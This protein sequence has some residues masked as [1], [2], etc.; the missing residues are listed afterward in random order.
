MARVLRVHRSQ[1]SLVAAAACWGAA[2]VVSKRALDEIEPLALLPIELVVSV[3]VLGAATRLRHEPLGWSPEL[4]RLA[5]LGVLNPGLAY[6][7][8]LAGLARV[9]ASVSVLL[10]AL[11]PIVILGI[12]FV[13]LR[14]RVPPRLASCMA[15][16]LAGVVMV[17][18]QPGNHA[19]PVG[20]ALTTAGV[21]ACAVYTVLSSRLLVASTTV[22]VV[23]FVQQVAA[24]WFALA[25]FCG[26][27]LVSDPPS[28]AAVSAT[29][30]VSA[31]VA[32]SLYY[33]VAF[34]LYLAG[35][36]GVTASFAGLFIN[37]V[38]V[39][40]IATGYVVLDERL[41]PRQWTG[42]LTVVVAV[43]IAALLLGGRGSSAE[44][45]AERVEA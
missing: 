4:R 34:W 6:A 42:A 5:A 26:S 10:W 19:S 32:G 43:V 25:L 31:I 38:P 8:S 41:S 18:F 33:G 14:E 36:R 3:A 35:L 45:D 12:A 15:A 2:T 21:A 29:A 39:F 13:V 37:L 27:L 30:W 44:D 24:L 17:V 22:V 20:V 23:V 9:S 1:L 16:A 28:L 11:E 7:L 40:G